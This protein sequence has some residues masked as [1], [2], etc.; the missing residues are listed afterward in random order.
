MDTIILPEFESFVESGSEYKKNASYIQG[1]MDEFTAKTDELQKMMTM[2]AQSVN[3]IAT[4]INEGVNGVSGAAQST[5]ILVADMDK[6][7]DKMDDNKQI[8]QMLKNE[9]EVFTKF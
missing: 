5:Q 6:I 2:I 9:T 8:A 4:A 1:T 7:A 3:S